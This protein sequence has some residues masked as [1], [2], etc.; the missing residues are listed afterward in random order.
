M[1]TLGTADIIPSGSVDAGSFGCWRLKYRAGPHGIALGGGIM[2]STDSDTDWGKPQFQDPEG[3]DYMTVTTSSRK[4]RMSILFDHSGGFLSH[5]LRVNVYKHPL[6]EGEEII[7]TYGDRSFGS[8]G[9]RAQTFAEERRYFRIHVD[10]KGDGRFVE[11]SNPPCIQVVGGPASKLSVIAPSQVVIG[12]PFSLVIRALDKFGNPSNSYNGVVRLN[13]N[14]EIFNLPEKH[15]FQSDDHGVYRFNDLTSGGPGL[16]RIAASDEEN[17]I[18]GASNPIIS[19]DR[20]GE[21]GLYWGDLHGQVKLADKIPEYLRFGRDVS[22]LDFASHQ[23]ND[24]EI[25]K[26]HWEKTKKIIKDFNKP[27]NFV[28]FLGYE[29]SGQPEVGGDHNI[30]YLEDDKPIR[31]SGHEMIKDKSDIDTDLTHISEIYNKLGEEKAFLIPHV[32]GRPAN[33]TFHNP[34]LEPVIEVHSTHGTFEW[35]LK[36]AL[37]RGLKIGFVAGS[38]DYKLRL[39][40]AYPGIGDRRF[41][42]GGLTAIYARELTRQG[43]Y[44]ALKERRCYGT[45]GERIILKTSADGHM[46][47]EEYPTNNPPR[48][49]VQVFGTNDVEKVELFRCLE[50]IY[51]F[52][53][54]SSSPSARIKIAWGGA[55]RRRPYSGVLWEGELRIENGLMASQKFMPLD[56]ADENFGEITEK[57]F[58]WRTFTCG[59][60]DGAS[61]IVEGK[62]AE[63]HVSYSCT[64]LAHVSM[65]GGRRLC[66]PFYQQD[67]GIFHISVDELNHNPK[68]IDIGPVDRRISIRRLP[69]EIESSEINI[70]FVDHDF[71]SGSNSY[72]VKVTQ[73]DGEMAW[74]S[75]IYVIGKRT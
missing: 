45:T 72:W 60:E 43:I 53:E 30:Y 70:Q 5:N 21:F 28:V 46:M 67:R 75:P 69:E 33:L 7:I 54:A 25:S 50:K 10:Q 40:G 64:P 9:S 71:K 6:K 59:D 51:E 19:K 57:H 13:S 26:K 29:W 48:I 8:P 44:E 47:G 20:K 68:V 66:S 58:K 31:R 62:K 55:S 52:P 35:F 16:I 73:T 24:H 12:T 61:F 74:S 27:W 38:D 42:R 2:V 34:E 49:S 11:I 3:A 36:E 15:A 4:A 65:E 39:G 56:R 1:D 17:M 14:G 41:V 18:K 63:I 32:G 37:E 23:R 22:A